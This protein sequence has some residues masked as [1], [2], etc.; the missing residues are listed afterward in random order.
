MFTR[1][2]KKGFLALIAAAALFGFIGTMST[3]CSF[4]NEEEFYSDLVC[5]T[6]NV[7]YTASVKPVFTQ[8]CTS[9]HSDGGG[10]FPNL[11]N[12]TDIKDYI[13]DAPGEI[14]ARINHVVG[15]DPMPQGGQKL[16]VC[17]IR[18]IELWIMAGYPNN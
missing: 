8:A 9:C 1:K 13:D 11:D 5:D 7:T 14:P 3:G 17:D 12:Y 16:P 4:D 6:A 10:S 18:K 2:M 15:Y